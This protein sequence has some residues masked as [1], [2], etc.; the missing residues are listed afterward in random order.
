MLMVVSFKANCFGNFS[1]EI[2]RNS[3][4]TKPEKVSIVKAGF[5][6]FFVGF[7]KLLCAWIAFHEQFLFLP[8]KIFFLV[9]NSKP[10]CN[11]R[12]NANSNRP[13]AWVDMIL[14]YDTQVNFSS[15]EKAQFDGWFHGR[16]LWI[17]RS[18]LHG[19]EDQLG[20]PPRRGGRWGRSSCAAWGPW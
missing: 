12:R 5:R 15:N 4:D 8:L 2:Q 1:T 9:A 10:S 7:A 11:L 13:Q 18:A 6:S 14:L 19:A 3:L 16:L 17:V 20:S